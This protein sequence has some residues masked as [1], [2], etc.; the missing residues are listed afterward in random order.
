MLSQLG[1]PSGAPGVEVLDSTHSIAV[2]SIAT[3]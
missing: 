3:K 1:T 2:A